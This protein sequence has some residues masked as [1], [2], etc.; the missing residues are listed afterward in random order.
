MQN[1]IAHKHVINPDN[2]TL[3]LNWREGVTK[4]QDLEA[5]LLDSHGELHEWDEN[6][7]AVYFTYDWVISHYPWVKSYLLAGGVQDCVFTVGY[8]CFCARNPVTNLEMHYT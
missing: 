2:F 6:V 8:E 7:G 4:W 5:V 1:N 3:Q